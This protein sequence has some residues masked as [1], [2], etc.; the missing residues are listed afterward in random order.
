MTELQM[1]T[2][3]NEVFKKFIQQLQREENE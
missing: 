1:E 2:I 3:L